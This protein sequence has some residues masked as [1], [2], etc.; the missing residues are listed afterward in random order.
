MILYHREEIL[1]EYSFHC[2][3]C[4]RIYKSQDQGKIHIKKILRICEIIKL[5]LFNCNLITFIITKLN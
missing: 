4:S 5:V 3:N 1:P 2:K